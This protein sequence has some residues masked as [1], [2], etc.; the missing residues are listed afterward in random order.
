[1]KIGDI[2]LQNSETAVGHGCDGEDSEAGGDYEEIPDGK[3]E[4][5]E[6]LQQPKST[7]YVNVGETQL[8]EPLRGNPASSGADYLEILN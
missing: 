7:D 2:N 6:S 3:E 1:M 8:Y 4:Q 5:Y